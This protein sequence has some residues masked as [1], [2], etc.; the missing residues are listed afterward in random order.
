MGIVL[1]IIDNFS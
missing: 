1:L